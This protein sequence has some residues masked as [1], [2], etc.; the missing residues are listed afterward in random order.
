[1]FLNGEGEGG[2]YCRCLVFFNIF[3]PLAPSPPSRLRGRGEAGGGVRWWSRGCKSWGG[4]RGAERSR[5]GREAA[6]PGV[7]S[8]WCSLEQTTCHSS[9]AQR[10]CATPRRMPGLGVRAAAG[11][12][13]AGPSTRACE[14]A[15]RAGPST[16]PRG[17]GTE[18]AHRPVSAFGGDFE[19]PLENNKI[20]LQVFVREQA[21]CFV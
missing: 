6:E 9:P 18:A 14:G 4:R 5:A 16:R 19:Q 3:F 20:Y 11:R 1:M 10:A 2:C 8:S 17:G 7:P 21:F 12:D 13:G 15:A